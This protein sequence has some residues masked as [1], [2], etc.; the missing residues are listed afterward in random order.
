MGFGLYRELPRELGPRV[1]QLPRQF[2]DTATFIKDTHHLL[3][4]PR[5]ISREQGLKVFDAE[6][7]A[8][9]RETKLHQQWTQIP[10]AETARSHG[11]VI[12]QAQEQRLAG[13]DVLDLETGGWT[14]ITNMMALNIALHPTK[15]WIVF[16][17]SARPVDKPRLLAVVDWTTGAELFVR[18]RDADYVNIEAV[19][20]LGDEDGLVVAIPR[21]TADA[22]D[23]P[24]VVVELWRVG[25]PSRLEKVA[26]VS[27][28]G[29][30]P[31]AAPNGRL[32]W[33]VLTQGAEVVT[34]YDL[35]TERVL[36]SLGPDQASKDF[37]GR[38][39]HSLVSKG[40]RAVN[41]SRNGRGV[42]AGYPPRVWD[43]ASRSLLWRPQPQRQ[44]GRVLDNEIFT[45][46]E[47]WD[48]TWT[49]G[50]LRDWSTTALRDIDAAALRFRCWTRDASVL[51][52]RSADGALGVS[53]TGLVHRLPFRV[54]YPLLIL[55]QLIL[56][57]PLILLWLLL[58]F[59][60]RRASQRKLA[61]SAP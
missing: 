8:F 53:N 58:R 34:V 30:R 20:F 24:S 44:F 42:L 61:E 36:F 6:S 50:K 10:I 41:L 2:G 11:V 35:P 15:P 59:R 19:L 43:I 54:N 12:A 47:T 45:V 3:I 31:Q 29:L 55:C 57:L 17:E 39:L 28:F 13:L 40:Y 5:F 49:R 7:G 46:F 33:F 26:R 18:A 14:R 52:C 9:L 4:E 56:A 32:A 51:E 1:C 48:Q 22:S 27:Q 23:K 25:P 38:E 21:P 16:R 37:I 60:R